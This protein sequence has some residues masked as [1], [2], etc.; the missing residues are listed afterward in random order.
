MNTNHVKSGFENGEAHTR[1]LFIPCSN[2]EQHPTKETC[3]FTITWFSEELVRCA[4]RIQTQWMPRSLCPHPDPQSRTSSPGQE[5]AAHRSRETVTQ[6]HRLCISDIGTASKP[7]SNSTAISNGLSYAWQAL[8]GGSFGHGPKD[9]NSQAWSE[10][11]P[12]TH[13]NQHLQHSM[14][15]WAMRYDDSGPVEVSDSCNGPGHK[16][17]DSS[18]LFASKPAE[19][20]WCCPMCSPC[21]PAREKDCPIS[22]TSGPPALLHS[23]LLHSFRRFSRLSLPGSAAPRSAARRRTLPRRTLVDVTHGLMPHAA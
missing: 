1:H 12:M 17:L 18:P 4:R 15:K 5:H 6:T 2:P 11:Q 20:S 19:F 21:A 7:P 23:S 10:A 3:H 14:A 22:P 13:C 8:K 9:A 16:P